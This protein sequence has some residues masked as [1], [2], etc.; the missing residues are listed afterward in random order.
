MNRDS[1]QS[2]ESEF[3]DALFC[4]LNDANVRYAVMRNY[5]RLPYS[6]DGSDLDILILRADEER[7]KKIL[8]RTIAKAGG[9]TIGCGKSVGFFKVYALGCICSEKKDWWGLRID[10]NVGLQFRGGAKLLNMNYL[11]NKCHE[12]NGISVLPP[13]L[14]AVL[15]VLKEVLHNNHMPE[16]Y[17]GEAAQAVEI[18]WEDLCC[19]LKPMGKKAILILKKMIQA[20]S[21]PGRLASQAQALRR[22]LF[23]KSF[24]RAPF[25]YMYL[26][27][28]YEWSK[29][30]RLMNPSGVMVAVL[31]VDGVGKSTVIRHIMPVLKTATHSA[32][33]V[34]HLRP[35]LL[36]PLARLK[37]TRVDVP[38]PVLDPHGSKPSGLL[39]SLARMIYYTI[40]YVLGYWLWVRPKIAKQ[41]TVVL[42]DRYA[43]DMALDPRRFRIGFSGRMLKWFTR[44]APKPDVILCLHADPEVI[45]ARKQELA[46]D[47]V[48]RQLDAIR[49]FAIDEPRAVLV[50]TEEDAKVVRDHILVALR[51]TFS[52]RTC[53]SKRTL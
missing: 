44:L 4:S 1:V 27:F 24:S 38:G 49:A 51:E 8:I 7:V 22:V 23:W 17:H 33:I 20:E 30:R 6:A 18:T 37:G 52:R 53:N 15:G 41:P 50:S 12:H 46:I 45:N 3:L 13:G 35:G 2:S 39:G 40:D 48:Q 16:R 36:P 21:S 26:R 34:K 29:V 31:G 28:L 14:A 19:H 11:K 25:A 10:V 42:F 43:Y 32:F 5:E 9:V 47:E